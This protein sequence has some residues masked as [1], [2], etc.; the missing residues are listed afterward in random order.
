MD[1]TGHCLV[2]F[3]A[4]HPAAYTDTGHVIVPT[5]PCR[6]EGARQGLQWRCAKHW[7][8]AHD[9]VQALRITLG[10]HRCGVTILTGSLACRARCLVVAR[11]PR[12]AGR[13]R[14]LRPTWFQP[15]VLQICGA[16]V[17]VGHLFYIRST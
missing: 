8:I 10:T 4:S 17:R 12:A 1:T 5:R 3:L 9:L 13:A 7:P 11:T 15:E 2:L 16:G 14:A 6:A